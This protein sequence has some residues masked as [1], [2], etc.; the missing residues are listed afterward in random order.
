MDPIVFEDGGTLKCHSSLNRGSPKNLAWHIQYYLVHI[1]EKTI[2]DGTN[3][4]LLGCATHPKST[5]CRG[6]NLN[7]FL[8]C[9]VTYG[10]QPMNNPVFYPSQTSL[11]HRPQRS[12]RLS[13]PGRKLEPI[14]GNR[15]HAAAV[16][17][18]ASLPHTL[19]AQVF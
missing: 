10:G 4:S 13:Q 3:Q 2:N 9:S 6:G 12:G 11:F 18:S 7:A 17:S 19:L 8:A 5:R 15:V 1:K 16:A 14:T